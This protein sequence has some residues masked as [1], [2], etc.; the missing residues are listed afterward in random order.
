MEA[1]NIEIMHGGEAINLTIIPK[2]DYFKIAFAEG[3]LGAIKKEGADWFLMEP[4]NI[5]PGEV[6]A[7]DKLSPE[8]KHIVLGAAEINQIA[9]E[10]ENQLK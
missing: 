6:S 9:G 7:C 4:E 3:I 10:I 8:G 5:E 1:F 2:E